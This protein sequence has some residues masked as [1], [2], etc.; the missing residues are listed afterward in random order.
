VADTT[1]H[2]PG[3]PDNPVSD[4]DLEDKFRSLA[5]PVLGARR[6]AAV[7]DA[8]RDLIRLRDVSTLMALVRSG[9]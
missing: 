9:P 5:E 6:A 3:H 7:V 1:V 8:V 2:F 4:A